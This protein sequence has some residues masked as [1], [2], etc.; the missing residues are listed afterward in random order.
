MIVKIWNKQ[1]IS[2]LLFKKASLLKIFLKQPKWLLT[3]IGTK[4]DGQ[5]FFLTTV[6]VTFFKNGPFPAS[7][8][9]FSAFQYSW[10]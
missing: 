1:L 9:L 10:R 5:K 3:Y 2:F 8:S 4:E 7:F 6:G